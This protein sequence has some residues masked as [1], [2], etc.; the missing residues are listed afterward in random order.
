MNPTKNKYEV[1][2]CK[3]TTSKVTESKHRTEEPMTTENIASTLD[4]STSG[5]PGRPPLEPESREIRKSLEIL[6]PKADTEAIEILLLQNEKPLGNAHAQSEDDIET[7]TKGLME[8]TY[9]AAYVRPN[10]IMN[11]LCGDNTDPLGKLYNYAPDA[12]ATSKDIL[13]RDWLLVDFDPDRPSDTPSTEVEHEQAISM[14]R[15]V[16]EFL[17]KRGI[18]ARL[19]ADS[20]NG[21]HLVLRLDGLPADEDHRTLCRDF[22]HALGIQFDGAHGVTKVDAKTSDSTRLIRLY[23]TPNRKGVSTL[24]RPHRLSRI[25]EVDNEAESV[26]ADQIRSVVEEL[27]PAPAPAKPAPASA[28]SAGAPSPAPKGF[29]GYTSE[30][31]H[32]ILLGALSHIDPAPYADWIMVGMALHNWGREGAFDLWESWSRGPEGAPCDS[33]E[34][35][36][37]A[38]KWPSFESQD[39]AE[40]VT[41]GSILHMGKEAGW[42]AKGAFARVNGRHGGRPHG[43]SMFALDLAKLFAEAEAGDDGLPRFRFW[44]GAWHRFNGTYFER[45][46]GQEFE[47]LV[48]SFLQGRQEQMNA[49]GRGQSALASTR[50]CREV[51][52]ES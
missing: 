43:P 52:C 25:L 33:F 10:P 48:M 46:Q 26:T 21:A 4:N 39:G 34:E 11:P 6:R 42:N 20:G 44:I 1:V 19:L 49:E 24:E 2:E 12:C 51:I 23:G 50:M 29:D 14:A 35:G 16:R 18:H 3:S 17:G 38:S 5:G 28:K 9:D 27:K 30:E 13:R 41:V 7:L 45:M 8:E 37:C 47:G 32:E 40:V 15:E 31:Q 22:L 36:A